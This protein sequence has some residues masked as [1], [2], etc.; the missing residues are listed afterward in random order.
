M[1]DPKGYGRF[2]YATRDQRLAYRVSYGL[3]VGEIPEALQLDHLCRNTGCVNPYH[4]EPVTAAV[5]KAR[6]AE[7]K[8]HCPS[9]HP[10]TE[11]NTY[12]SPKG[13]RVCR[14]CRSAT[15]RADKDRRKEQRRARGPLPRVRPTHCKHGH[16]FD[17][18]NTYLYKGKYHCRACRAARERARTAAKKVR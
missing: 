4:L 15:Q 11:E 12:R 9:G 2:Q 5:N 7:A 8:T 18:A 10:Y 1:R 3:M 6:A 16:A 14:T 13:A 17:E